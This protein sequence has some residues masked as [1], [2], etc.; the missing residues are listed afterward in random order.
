MVHPLLNYVPFAKKRQVGHSWF[1]R[2][3]APQLIPVEIGSE[4]YCATP[5]WP[6]NWFGQAK[7]LAYL[8]EKRPQVRPNPAFMDLLDEWEQLALRD[9]LSLG[10]CEARR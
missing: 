6:E 8:R 3:L 10:D 2:Q 7:A 4:S 1:V 5:A 9:E